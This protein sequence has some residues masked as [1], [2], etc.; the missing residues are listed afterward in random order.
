VQPG[1]EGRVEEHEFEALG[2]AGRHPGQGV[3]TL[4]PHGR[5][6]Q[7]CLAARRLRPAPDR[8]PAAPPRPHRATPPRTR[9]RRCRRR[10]PDN[11]SR[12]RSWPSQLNKVS[13]TRSGVGRRPGRSATGSLLRF[14]CPPISAPRAGCGAAAATAW[15]R[16]PHCRTA[17][18]SRGHQRLGLADREFAVVEDAGRQHRVGAADADAFG[19]VFECADA[20]RRDHRH[21]HRIADGARQLEIEADLGA[22]AVHAGEQD[23]AGSASAICRAQPTASSPVL[24]AATVG[25]D[26]PA[27]PAGLRVGALPALGID[28]HHDALR[29]VLLAG[30]SRITCGLATAAELKLTLSAPALSSGARLRPCARRRPRSAG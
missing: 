29:T 7:R 27:R 28:G 15:P 11:A 23:L 3:G 1:V 19:Q 5:S 4:H 14:H 10:H 16:R 6:A 17:M 25:V 20:A 22:V 12:S 8:A 30:A 24:L 26:I 21:R 18:P 2:R 9:A 13:R